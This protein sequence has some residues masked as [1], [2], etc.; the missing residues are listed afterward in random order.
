M[1]LSYEA[2]LALSNEEQEAY[3]FRFADPL[4]YAAWLKAA[5]K[6]YEDDLTSIIV[7]GPVDLETLKTHEP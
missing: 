2:F 7:T 1:L 5:K 6:A 3:F 4:D